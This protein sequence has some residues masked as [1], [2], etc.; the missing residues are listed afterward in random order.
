MVDT[1]QY[2]YATDAATIFQA[3]RDLHVT[4]PPQATPGLGSV[5]VPE[6]LTHTVCG[7]D[8]LLNDLEVLIDHGGQVVVLH[9]NGGYGK[10]TVA[11]E[12]AKRVR[13]RVE[14]W[15][16]DGTSAGHIAED[17]RGVAMRAGAAPGAVRAAWSGGGSAPDLPW[18]ALD[19]HQ[20][21]V[22]IT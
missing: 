13:Q 15:W 10:T 20:D 8:A 17:L 9:G 5:G 6:D 11:T 19:E 21:R 2:A 14:V 1:W 4:Q 16:V 3:G 22:K 7:R 18:S 12:L